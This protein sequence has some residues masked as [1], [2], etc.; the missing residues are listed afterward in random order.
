MTEATSPEQGSEPLSLGELGAMLNESEPEEP[1]VNRAPDGDTTPQSSQE[2]DVAEGPEQDPD[3]TEDEGEPSEDAEGDD[4]DEDE[5]E[6]PEAKE[7]N[8]DDPLVTVTTD[9]KEEEVPLSELVKGYHRSHNYEKKSQKVSESRK[10]LDGELQQVRQERQRY[11]EELEQVKNV[12]QSQLDEFANVD[13]DDLAE[14][15]PT[16]YTRLKH[17]QEK[18]ANASKAVEER[19]RAAFEKQEAENKQRL[20]EYIQQ[21]VKKLAETIPDFADPEKGTKKQQQLQAYLKKQ[22]FTNDDTETLIDARL[23]TLVEKA[24]RWDSAQARKGEVTSK[25]KTQAKFKTPKGSQ[26]PREAK[27]KQISALKRRT[28]TTGSAQDLGQLLTALEM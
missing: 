7:D 23:I 21:Q 19:Q 2:T 17:L 15:D 6:K 14:N 26:E 9:G 22:G 27:A 18:K 4:A 25:L 10:E 12:L 13:W 24:R 1:E 20:Q 11:A 28:E 8:A 3:D 5:A 16:E